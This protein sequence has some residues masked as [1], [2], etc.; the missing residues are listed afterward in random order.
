MK[1]KDTVLEIHGFGLVDL[2][3]EEYDP[4][5]RIIID[6]DGVSVVRDECRLPRKKAADLLPS[7]TELFRTHECRRVDGLKNRESGSE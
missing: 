4:H 3:R 7:A 5:T 2:L 1:N 6:F